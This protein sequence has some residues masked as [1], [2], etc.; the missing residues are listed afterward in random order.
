MPLDE[1][2]QIHVDDG[3]VVVGGDLD[4]ATVPLL[5]SVVAKLRPVAARHGMAIYLDL[6]GVRFI[7]STGLHLLLDLRRQRDPIR[8]VATSACVDRLLDITQT[9]EFVLDAEPWTGM[10]HGGGQNTGDAA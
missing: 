10:R 3:C 8:V 5:R 9:R 7:D 2:I 6:G 1:G 4:L